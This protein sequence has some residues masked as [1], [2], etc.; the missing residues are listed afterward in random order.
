MLDE[1]SKR[2][3]FLPRPSGAKLLNIAMMPSSIHNIR[4]SF[5]S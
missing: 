2:T 3:H 4:T 5:I 1:T